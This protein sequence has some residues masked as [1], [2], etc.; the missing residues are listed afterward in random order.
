MSMGSYRIWI[1]D[2][3]YYFNQLEGD[4]FT[5]QISSGNANIKDYDIIICGKN[6]AALAVG[7]KKK[8]PEKKVGVI[9]LAADKK[10]PIDFVIVG[11]LEEKDSLS[12]YDNVFLYPLIEKMY[13]NHELKVHEEK[14]KIRIG[15]HGHYPHLAK[16]EPHLKSA[17]ESIDKKYDIELLIVT[18]NASFNWKHGRPNIKNIIMKEWNINSI[19]DNI[20][21]CDIGI[22]PNITY[23]PYSKGIHPTSADLGLY[24]TDHIFRLKN[25]SNAG[26][27]FVFHQLGI[28]VVGDFT[29]SNFHIMG[30]PKC[31]YLAHNS[32]TWERA[33]EDL[34]SYEKRN[35]IAQEAK[36]EFDR[37]YNP[38]EW[39]E[40]LY[41]DIRRIK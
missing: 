36:K 11:S 24:D 30:D 23:I 27:A 18:S 8:Y 20:M 6:D 5:S 21:S 14:S 35:F 26:R 39:A 22:V 9:N 4:R 32:K 31:G 40:R 38:L 19:K 15:F 25:K 10:L 33:L 12:Y 17:I 29:P 41:E 2:L 1:N 16:F 7:I 34:M 37:L 28:P 13:Q 3:N